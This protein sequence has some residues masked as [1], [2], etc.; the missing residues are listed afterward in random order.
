VLATL[1]QPPRA[2]S[3]TISAALTALDQQQ[4]A[5]SAA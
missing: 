4:R 1:G 5:L 2:L 3:D